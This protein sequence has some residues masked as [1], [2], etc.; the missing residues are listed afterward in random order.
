M[1]RLQASSAGHCANRPFLQSGLGPVILR[2]LRGHERRVAPE[3]D[4]GPGGEATNVP[5]E[6]GLLVPVLSGGIVESEMHRFVVGL[7]DDVGFVLI[8]IG[9]QTPEVERLL[10]R[11]DRAVL[12]VASDR[13]HQIETGLAGDLDELVGDREVVTCGLRIVACVSLE[14]DVHGIHPVDGL[15]LLEGLDP[16]TA[17]AVSAA[18][19]TRAEK[20][21]LGLTGRLANRV[22][23]C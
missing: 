21:S 23:I 6:L 7:E 14:V 12:A 1:L 15:E 13:D 10:H 3:Q 11:V 19:S 9:V 4:H 22:S 2:E 8:S 18:S 20:S 5:V 17:A 16:E